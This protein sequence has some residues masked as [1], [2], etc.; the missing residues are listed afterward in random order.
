M[1]DGSACLKLDLRNTCETD[2]IPR[3]RFCSPLGLAF[4]QAIE[5]DSH[6]T[7]VHSSTAQLVMAG[8]RSHRIESDH[9]LGGYLSIFGVH[10][11]LS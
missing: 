11:V 6:I 8:T 4:L 7:Q 10:W 3:F 1:R 9:V 5:I 2:R